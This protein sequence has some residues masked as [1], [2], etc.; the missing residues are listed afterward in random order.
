MS[1]LVVVQEPTRW[2]RFKGVVSDTFSNRASKAV[3]VATPFVLSATAYANESGLP[4]LTIDV[5][6]LMKGMAVVI[7]ACATVGMGVLTVA[8]TA[9]A[10]KYIRTAF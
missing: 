6:G 4:E 7:A 9:K 1:N 8:L 2:Q 3:V 10:F 5:A